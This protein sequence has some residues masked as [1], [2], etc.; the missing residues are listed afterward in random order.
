MSVSEYAYINAKIRVKKGDLLDQK[1]MRSL[2]EV[3]ETKEMI[4][5]LM[6]TT[7]R[8]ELSSLPPDATIRDIERAI[9]DNMVKTF[10][11]IASA[12]GTEGGRALCVELLRRFEVANLKSVLRAK[13]SGLSREEL[14]LIPVEGFFR[15]RL[16]RLIDLASI[17]EMI[18]LLEGT[19]YR[20]ILEGNMAAFKETKKLFVLES[21]LDAELF[22]SIWLQAKKLK[23]ADAAS[24]MKLLGTRFDMMNMMTILRGKADGIEISQLRNYI[25]PYG[26]LNPDLLRDAMMADDVKSTLQVLSTTQYA[27]IFAGAASEYDELGQLSSFEVALQRR[28]L[29]E[30]RSLMMGYPFQIGTIIG[31]FELKE[32]E[33]KNLRAIAVC[34]ENGLEAE[35]TRRFII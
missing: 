31:F 19:P 3:Y 20:A 34:K 33:V 8:D 21:A 32:A 24:A 14:D 35:E 4:A 7:Y 10:V 18:P 13:L 16:S 29:D 2:M 12:V 28:I 1:K 30:S 25:L 9:M 15:R 26:R 22:Q 11:N 17:E 6:D 23:G 27:D 5:L